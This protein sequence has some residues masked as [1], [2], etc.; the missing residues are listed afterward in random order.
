MSYDTLFVKR[1]QQFETPLK[2][3]SIINWDKFNIAAKTKAEKSLEA[4]AEDEEFQKWLQ[5]LKE[6]TT[7]GHPS[8]LREDV[9]PQQFVKLLREFV[10]FGYSFQNENWQDAQK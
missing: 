6:T 2:D 8:L 9:E 10:K 7:S 1:C 3:Y 5:N 4:G